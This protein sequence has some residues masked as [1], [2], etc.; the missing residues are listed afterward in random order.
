M[1]EQQLMRAGGSTRECRCQHFGERGSRRLENGRVHMDAPETV[2]V[3]ILEQEVGVQW[4]SAHGCTRVSVQIK[5]GGW[6]MV[7][8]CMWMHEECTCAL[9]GEGGRSTVKEGRW[10]HQEV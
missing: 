6:S 5:T 1:L 9:F 3:Y 4:R 2:D 8:E 7:E 10:M